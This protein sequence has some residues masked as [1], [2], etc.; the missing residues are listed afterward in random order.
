MLDF[1][2]TWY[3]NL[4]TIQGASEAFTDRPQWFKKIA[5]LMAREEYKD[6]ALTLVHQHVKLEQGERMVATGLITQPEGVP[7]KE[8][9]NVIPSAW[10]AEGK[11]FEWLRVATPED[12]LPP[13]PAELVKEFRAIVAEDSAISR[14]LGLALRP[15][16][17]SEE[18]VWCERIEHSLRQQVYSEKERSKC[19]AS[20]YESCWIP[21]RTGSTEMDIV[22]AYCCTCPSTWH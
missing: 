13:P 20:L 10:T 18:Y 22:M 12:L 9:P 8:H 1:D 14:V 16:H 11:P 21:K 7:D 3:N 19:S 2:H 6:Y 5:P 4:P 17:L 15:G